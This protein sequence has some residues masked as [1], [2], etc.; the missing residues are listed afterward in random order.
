MSVQAHRVLFL[1]NLELFPALVFYED[2]APGRLTVA[3]VLSTD[4]SIVSHRL[5]KFYLEP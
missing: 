1:T 2:Y 4:E 5:L 3:V